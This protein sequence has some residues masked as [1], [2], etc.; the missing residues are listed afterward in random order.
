MKLHYHTAWSA[1]ISGI[2]FMIFKSWG[3]TLASF[4]TGIFIDLDHFIDYAREYGS[5]FK[6]KNFFHICHSCQFN[7]IILLW[8][9]WEWIILI[10]IIAWLTDWNPWVTGALIGFTHHMLLDA[11][12]N[13]S[14]LWSYS[15]IWR[16]KNNFDFDTVFSNL[17]SYKYKHRKCESGN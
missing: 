2:L 13:S 15:L 4:I 17:K 3:I 8:H 12:F 9:G 10:A 5:P 7:K 1:L 16:W 6:I 14:N 11:L